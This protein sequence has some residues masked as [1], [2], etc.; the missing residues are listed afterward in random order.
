MMK[1][2]KWG[3]IASANLTKHPT[4]ILSSYSDSELF[5]FLKTGV[6]RNGKMALPMMPKLG[7]MSDE[8]LFSVIAFLRSDHALVEATPNLVPDSEPS[9]LV[10]ALMKFEIKPVIGNGQ[11]INTPSLENTI[12]YGSY[13]VNGRYSCFEC[14][15]RSTAKVDYLHPQNSEGYLGGGSNLMVFGNGMGIRSAN[16]TPHLTAGIGSWTFNDFKRAVQEGNRPDGRT[17]RPPMNRMKLD[18]IEITSIWEYLKTV[19]PNSN[20]WDYDDR[21]EIAAN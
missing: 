17:L 9:F 8:D 12:L 13:L 15:S 21:I 6:K 3:T 4:S 5:S 14:H 11:K 18:S 19:A 2:Q 16:I 1:H 7:A 10:K 20:P